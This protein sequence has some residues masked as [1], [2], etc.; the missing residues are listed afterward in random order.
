MNPRKAKT[1]IAVLIVVVVI[2]LTMNLILLGRLHRTTEKAGKWKKAHE[3]LALRRSL[4]EKQKESQKLSQ[5]EKQQ[6]SGKTKHTLQSMNVFELPKRSTQS[7]AESREY[8]EEDAEENNDFF[9]E[10]IQDMLTEALKE[11]FPELD[12]NEAEI[13]ELTN[14]VITI[15]QS[16][17]S[18]RYMERSSENVEAIKELQERRDH[19]M[20][21]FER[22]TGMSAMEF[23][24]RAPEEGGIDHE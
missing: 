16:L 6:P 18:M 7:R 11:E 4:L 17:E 22:I 24:L 5:T 15:R 20:W 3:N 12:L 2:S 1:L 14:V 10:E 23:M 13:E 9:R 19:A 21:D 8:L